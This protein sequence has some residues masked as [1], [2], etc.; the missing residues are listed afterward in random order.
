MLVLRAFKTV[1]LWLFVSVV[2]AHAYG[3]SVQAVAF[4]S[5][6]GWSLARAGLALL[7]GIGLVAAAGR[8]TGRRLRLDADG[9]ALAILVACL[10]ARADARIEPQ[11]TITTLREGIP[12]LFAPLYLLLT[13]LTPLGLAVG[14][15]RLDAADQ[16]LV[17]VVALLTLTGAPLQLEAPLALGLG[18][19]PLLMLLASGRFVFPRSPLLAAAGALVAVVGLS[20]WHG[21]NPLAAVPS[22]T[23]TLTLALVGLA[24][25]GRPR[26]AADWRRLLAAPVVVAVLVAGCA[27]VQTAYLAH[28]VD[29][30]AALGTRLHVFQQHPNFLA[31]FFGAHALLAAA[32]AG[33][34]RGAA[35]V[36]GGLASAAL[37]VATLMT[38]SKTG[39]AA[40]AAGFALLALVFASRR[41]AARVRLR[42]GSV[43]AIGLAIP[44]ALMALLVLADGSSWMRERLRGVGGRLERSLD[45]RVDAWRNSLAVIRE[46]PWLGIGPRT[47]VTLERWSPQSRFFNE[48]ESPHPHNQLLAVAQASGLAALALFVIWTLLLCA[49]L[50]NRFALR[51]SGIP[52]P[53]L[54]G[55]LAVLGMLVLANLFDLGL[56]LD[57]LVPTPFFLLTGLTVATRRE[58]APARGFDDE[59]V[60][61]IQGLLVAGGLGTILLGLSLRPVHARTLLAQ[62]QILQYDANQEDEDA[63]LAPKVRRALERALSLDP[64]V[65]RGF[66]LLSRWRE[67]HGDLAGARDAL[68]ELVGLAP[69]HGPHLSLLASFFRRAGDPGKAAHWYVRAIEAQHGSAFLNRERAEL[70]QCL[71]ATGRG[72]DAKEWLV[73]ALQLDPA[74]MDWIAWQWV[75][76]QRV[77]PV[78]GGEPVALMTAIEDLYA[79]QRA[80]HAAG[81]PVGRRYWMQTFRCFKDAGAL[82]RAWLVLDELDEFGV[83]EDYSTANERGHIASERG[84]HETAAWHYE[85]AFEKSKSVMPE[86][87]PFFRQHAVA[88]RARAAELE[89][90]AEAADDASAGE[91]P[92]LDGATRDVLG[93][94]RSAPRPPS[95][96]APL[97]GEASPGATEPEPEPTPALRG[98]A[99]AAVEELRLRLAQS[100]E[101]LDQPALQQGILHDLADAHEQAG[102]YAEAA[103]TLRRTLLFEDDLLERARLLLR[104][105]ALARR[106]G[107]HGPA[108][109]AY[110]EAMTI[111]A[112]RPYPWESLVED[113]TS[114]LPE[115]AARG[116]DA[117]WR[118]RG[119]AADA[120]LAAAWERAWFFSSRVA[121]SLFR[122]GLYR[123]HARV[124]LLLREAELQQRIDP[125][126]ALALWARLDGVEASGR[127][128]RAREVMRDLAEQ[129]GSEGAT[130]RWW[131][132]LVA[133]VQADM[134]QLSDPDVQRELGVVSLLM[135]RYAEAV[136]RFAEARALLEGEPSAQADAAAWEARAALLAGDLEGAR[137]ALRRAAALDPDD[138]L[139]AARLDALP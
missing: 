121:P 104:A 94:A 42:P 91:A 5:R 66:E 18:A 126:N 124:D 38:D 82:D 88:A 111:L 65:P 110:D 81:E 23:W 113:H 49:R 11:I 15:G 107:A 64:M 119:L 135:G 58:G 71:A 25:A 112:A 73:E 41:F 138:P 77:L 10:C 9:W 90:A 129:L 62:A 45:Y 31:P 52:P 99:R 131:D 2:V 100:D 40:T 106:G 19:L 87:N 57:T 108:L 132:A 6:V 115:H 44:L 92:E 14:R 97:A 109:E 95:A 80:R 60:R 96:P 48:P 30:R 105:G 50:W 16:T 136:P 37:L 34:T 134:D 127:L 67:R 128:D 101:I 20:T 79:R 122:L 86:G 47:F 130:Q 17:L 53:L 24:V 29:P 36:L 51:D 139:V 43:V 21:D 84:D 13:A 75:D 26:A 12:G 83:V 102:A 46:N 114:S 56:S 123:C 63:T 54:A 69:R 116:M 118:A 8:L 55:A 70:I 28:L 4:D 125:Q 32:L 7:V 22:F 133:R 35:R 76:G 39:I 3:V 27:F 61:P 33:G 59:R 93:A 137:A 85:D 117:S 1:F 89:A 68:L 78:A 120:R 74:I 98:A 72:E 103:A